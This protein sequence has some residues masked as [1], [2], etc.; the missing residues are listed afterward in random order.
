MDLPDFADRK[1]MISFGMI[2]AFFETLCK[3]G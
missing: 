3:T 2:L 1:K